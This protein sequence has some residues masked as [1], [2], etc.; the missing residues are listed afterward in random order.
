MD[1]GDCVELSFSFSRNCRCC[2]CRGKESAKL[3]AENADLRKRVKDLEEWKKRVRHE[4]EEE[5]RD[6]EYW[7]DSDYG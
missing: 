5:N 6:K 1:C 3:K 4:W 7:W 2:V